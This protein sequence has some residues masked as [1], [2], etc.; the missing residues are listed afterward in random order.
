MFSYNLF[1]IIKIR[2]F[3]Q[4]D[5]YKNE[6]GMSVSITEN[7]FNVSIGLTPEQVPDFKK[8]LNAARI[9]KGKASFIFRGNGMALTEDDY[10][11]LKSKI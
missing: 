5:I 1:H 6:S 2:L 9:E 11:D 3:R 4:I 8:A 10:L 7:S